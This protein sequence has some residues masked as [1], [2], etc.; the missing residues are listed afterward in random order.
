MGARL[1]LACAGI[2]LSIAVAAC[3]TQ[4]AAKA[5]QPRSELFGRSAL[6]RPIASI[7]ASGISLRTTKPLDLA[8]GRSIFGA[9]ASTGWHEHPGPGFVQVT[10]GELT[11]FDADCSKRTISKGRAVIDRPG[12]LLLARNDGE[13]ETFLYFTFLLPRGAEVSTPQKAPAHCDER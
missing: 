4:T 6:S 10:A 3:G 1:R 11:M 7:E 13:E 2:T 5:P 9:G 12:K 8:T